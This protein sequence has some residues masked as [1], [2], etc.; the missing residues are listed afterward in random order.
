MQMSSLKDKFGLSL[1]NKE[2]GFRNS[3]GDCIEWIYGKQ[4]WLQVCLY[5]L[6]VTKIWFKYKIKG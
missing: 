4:K 6:N 5:E 2:I 1:K 3:W